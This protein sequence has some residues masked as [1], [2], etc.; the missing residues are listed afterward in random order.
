M[1]YFENFPKILYDYSTDKHSVSY[2]LSDITRNVRF[3]KQIL[4]DIT[5]FE[6]Y[7]IMDGETPEIIAEKI[8][9]SPHYHW[10][11]MLANE[12]YNWIEDYPLTDLELDEYIVEK[13]GSIEN[14]HKTVKYYLN[15]AGEVVYFNQKT[16]DFNY[17]GTVTQLSC[18]EYEHMV[19]EGKRTIKLISPALV[20]TILKN[21]KDVL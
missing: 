6:T 2:I 14:A 20:N 7:D 15:S 10:I 21:Y 8:Y 5:L 3:R 12:T 9:G 19:N 13:Y 1:K 18:Y 17:K 4:S 11:V 16:P